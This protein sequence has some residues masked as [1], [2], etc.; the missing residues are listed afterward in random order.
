MA[1]C[2]RCYGTVLGLL[3]TRLLL[4]AYGANQVYWLNQYGWQGALLTGLLILAYPAELAAQNYG[5]WGL[6]HGVMAFFGFVSGVALGL[7]IMPALHAPS[8]HCR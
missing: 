5:L 7:S 2:M 6:N 8:I 1:V 3:T 4:A